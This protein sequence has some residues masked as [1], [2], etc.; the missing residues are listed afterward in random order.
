VFHPGKTIEFT[1]PEIV[2]P[3]DRQ[4]ERYRSG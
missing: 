1:H 3:T 2:V 4:T